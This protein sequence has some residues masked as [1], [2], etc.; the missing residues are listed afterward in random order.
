MNGVVPCQNYTFT[1]GSGSID[2]GR[3]DTG[4]HTDDVHVIALPFLYTLYDQTFASVEA[5]SNGHLTFGTE[6]QQL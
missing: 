5:G 6:Q 3:P 4:N 1:I 2:P